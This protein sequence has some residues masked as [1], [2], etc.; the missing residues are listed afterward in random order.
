[1]L[2]TKLAQKIIFE[3]AQLIFMVVVLS[4]FIIGTTAV[5]GL[6]I[7]VSPLEVLFGCTLICF[8]VRGIIY[9][10]DRYRVM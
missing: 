8:A 9:L 3:T 2:K 1:M 4:G 7:M 6:Q 10:D 5:L